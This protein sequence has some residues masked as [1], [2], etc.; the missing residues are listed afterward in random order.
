[1][2][3]RRLLLI[4]CGMA[5]L[6]SPMSAQD[7]LYDNTFPLG[8]VKLLDGPFKHACDLN[9]ET[10]LKYDVDRLLAPFLKEAG[11]TPKAESFEIVKTLT[12]MSA[13]A[14]HY[15]ATGNVVRVSFQ[16][17]PGH[18]AGGVFGVRLLTASDK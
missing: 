6:A 5:L 13:L 4:A 10:L 7:K 17:R 14:I 1:M 18:T 12:D 2:K 11:L 9:V 15:A 8:R 3:F 16:S